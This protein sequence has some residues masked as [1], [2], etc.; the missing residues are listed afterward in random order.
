MERKSIANVPIGTW[1]AFFRLLFA[2]N[3]TIV[4]NG[5]EGRSQSSAMSH[6]GKILK[7]ARAALSLSREAVARAVGYELRTITRIEA[8]HPLVSLAAIEAVKRHY[9]KNGIVF[10]LETA[11]SGPGLFLPKTDP[12]AIPPKKKRT[13]RPAINATKSSG[14]HKG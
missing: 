9:E 13:R 6:P 8:E 5:L 14:E 1:L 3:W 12:I 2:H 11:D 7:A 10:Y 4:D